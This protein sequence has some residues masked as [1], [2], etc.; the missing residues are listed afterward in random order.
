MQNTKRQT[1]EEST[2]T[3]SDCTSGIHK[4]TKEILRE[5]SE[6]AGTGTNEEMKVMKSP[7]ESNSI[8]FD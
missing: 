5:E 1:E 3:E 7:Q 4:G 6:D 2:A 8:R